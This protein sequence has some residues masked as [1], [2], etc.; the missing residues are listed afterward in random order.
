MIN[1]G[2]PTKTDKIPPPSNSDD[3]NARSGDMDDNFRETLFSAV[4]AQPLLNDKE[5]GINDGFRSV[6]FCGG[7]DIGIEC[8]PV[9]STHG[10]HIISSNEDY[11]QDRYDICMVFPIL[12]GSGGLSFQAQGEDSMRAILASHADTY[13]Y[14]DVS[15]ENIFVLIRYPEQVLMDYA[16]VIE[17]KMKLDPDQILH[18]LSAGDAERNI[19]P[20]FI[21]RHD[22]ITK[23]PPFEHIYAP[24][25][26]EHIDMFWKPAAT[27]HPFTEAVRISL[28]YLLLE[29]PVANG[30]AALSLRALEKNKH[31]IDNFPMP[32]KATLEK[33]SHIWL[34]LCF[35]PQSQPFDLIRDYYGEKINIYFQFCGHLTSWL[36]IPAVVGLTFEAVVVSRYRDLDAFSDAV[37][38]FFCLV[39]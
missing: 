5:N 17:Y 29:G 23:I 30:G 24:F 31:L 18:H 25:K 34:S 37:I 3:I 28:T 38:P 21:G 13:S 11:H 26:P 12:K 22:D 8:G 4:P 33:L 16:D 39:W 15:G 35:T 9:V 14:V 6:P 1:V 10:G 2:R 20:V 36:F 19:G 7:Y 27:S 32:S